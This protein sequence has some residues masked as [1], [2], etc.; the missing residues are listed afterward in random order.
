[1]TDR[2]IALDGLHAL[3]P[4]G[5]ADL[6]A[7]GGELQTRVDR[8]YIVDWATLAALTGALAADHRVLDI[9]GRRTFLY[10]SVYFD[11]PQLSTFHAHVQGR[12]HRFKVRA[13]LYVD[14][15]TA[16]VEVK[17]KGRRGQTVKHRLPATPEDHGRLTPAARAFVADRLR[18]AHGRDAP[19][20]LVPVLGTH[21]R[22]I[23]L[24]AATGDERLTVDYDVHFPGAPQ[25]TSL[26]GGH[27]IVETK[28]HDGRGRAD[29][30]LRALGA[31]PLSCSKYV[32]GIGVTGRRP[33]PAEA[34]RIVRRYFTQPAEAAA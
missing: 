28:S 34:R 13:R 33:T 16:F 15:E 21:Y 4:I 20:D 2:A 26:S 11:S 14:T 27:V 17:L 31:R 19:G 25:A 32:V 6:L 3:A 1:M 12:R 29:R 5:L 23:T 9:D 7:A 24:A 8:K 30:A 22:R 18:E 10:D